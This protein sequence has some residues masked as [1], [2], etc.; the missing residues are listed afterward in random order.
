MVSKKNLI[1]FTGVSLGL[2][3]V[4]YVLCIVG[5]PIFLRLF[6]AVLYNTVIEYN[7]IVNLGLILGFVASLFMA[8]ILSQG[9][10]TLHTAIE[11]IFGAVYAG[12]AYIFIESHGIWGLAAVTLG[13]NA[14]KL[15]VA[16]ACLFA[17]KGKGEG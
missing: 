9:R 14:V 13:V 17:K 15:A 5:T 1:K 16:L 8:L 3:G 2:G 12:T 11:C 10:T 6:Y 4:F 7:Y